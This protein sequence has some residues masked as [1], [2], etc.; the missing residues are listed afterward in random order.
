[1]DY[2]NLLLCTSFILVFYFFFFKPQVE[3]QKKEKLF[4]EK[5]KKGDP[6]IVCGGILCKYDSI[7][8]NMVKA[9]IDKN[10]TITVS[11]NSVNVL[12]TIDFNNKKIKKS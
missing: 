11:I 6:I 9:I 8:E 3:N 10:I 1:M 4:W 5:I 2:I 12:E 7:E